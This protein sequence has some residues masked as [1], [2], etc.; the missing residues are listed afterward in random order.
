MS[1]NH[2]NT[3]ATIEAL[4]MAVEERN[5]RKFNDLYERFLQQY[6]RFK[7]LQT[8]KKNGLEVR[9][10]IFDVAANFRLS[11]TTDEQAAELLRKGKLAEHGYRN[12]PLKDRLRFLQ[13]LKEKIDVYKNE[14]ILTI[15]ADTG[16]PLDNAQSEMIKGEQWFSFAEKEAP[17]QLADTA[18]ESGKVTTTILPMGIAQII[19]A[20]NY[21]YALAIGGIVGALATGNSVIISPPEKAPNWIF[22]FMQA[23]D[24][25]IEAWLK[26]N[27]QRQ[28]KEWVQIREHGAYLIQHSMGIN[29][30][31]TTQ[32]DLVHFV[33]SNATGELIQKSRFSGSKKNIL[34]LGGVNMVI[35]MKSALEKMEA[36]KIAQKIYDG[37][38]PASGQRCTAPRT[39]FVQ[40]GAEAVIQKI[41]EMC[42][43]LPGPDFI[44]N[45]FKA[46]I[47][48][49]PLVD[50]NALQKMKD[51][52][53]LANKLG[54]VVHGEFQ[55]SDKIAPGG[56]CWVNPIAI[57]WSM[58]DMDKIGED[59]LKELHTLWQDEIF[60]PLIHIV[61]PV[62]DLGEAVDKTRLLDH[63]RL[64]GSVFSNDEKDV[65]WYQNRTKVT[66]V[67][68]NE[69]PKDL[70]PLG[71]HGHTRGQPA[72]G[73]PN[74]FREY[75]SEAS[76][77]ISN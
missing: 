26:E 37:F 68:F 17:K 15:T 21:P 47:K 36:T 44:G 19:G 13:I 8:D 48:M 27:E 25:A 23:S 20:Y 59:N 76:R 71:I 42:D 65:S 58:I 53:A 32:V 61:H 43:H 54:A 62:K 33:G 46:G 38:A 12:I 50:K 49:G 52:I 63:H 77:N 72:I 60:G 1:N 51:A 6:K 3:S 22:P 2:V 7:Q 35:V 67:M 18:D 5:S 34:E 9:N 57:D 45:P 31:L 69:A 70:S 24:E 56:H 66:S 29:R 16:K 4:K 55:V 14:I 39:L 75:G 11:I 28:G 10:V 73:G 30:Y 64:S 41:T 40:H 74:H